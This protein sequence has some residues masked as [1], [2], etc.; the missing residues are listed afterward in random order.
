MLFK[1]ERLGP[2]KKN[3][4]ELGDITLLLGPPNT[5]KSYTLKALYAKLFPLD[6][7]TFNLLRRMLS[8]LLRRHLD[9]VFPED[10]LKIL[11][12]L[13]KTWIETSVIVMV[14]PIHSDVPDRMNETL[15]AL[16]GLVKERN[17]K[18]SIRGRGDTLFVSVKTPPIKLKLDPSI[19]DQTLND[20][21]Y[22]FMSN[23]IPI[24]DIDSAVLDPLDVSRVN[25]NYIMRLF[26]YGT[27]TGVIVIDSRRLLAILDEVL[28]IYN[29]VFERLRH[30]YREL[31]RVFFSYRMLR[32]SLARFP[33]V[34]LETRISPNQGDLE[35]DSVINLTFDFNVSVLE[36]YREEIINIETIRKI[37]NEVF[38]E[39]N[40]SRRLQIIVNRIVDFMKTRVLKAYADT[41]SDNAYRFLRE[42]IV[43]KLGYDSLY[44]IPFGRSTVLLELES[45]SR[46]PYIRA[47]YLHN[48]IDELYPNILASYAY[49]ASRGRGLLL[50]G[51]LTEE[52]RKIL[53]AAKPLLEGDLSTDGSGRLIYRDWRDSKVEMHMASALVGE[54]SG[55][56]LP[57]L[58][59]KRKPLIL[60]EE[61]EAQLHPG[62]Q[63]IMALFIASLPKLC[64]CRIV[65]STHSDLLAITLSQLAVQKPNREWIEE[66]VKSLI[67]HMEKN[68]ETLTNAVAESIKDLEVRIYEYTRQGTVEPVKPEDI[69]SKEVPG[70]SRVIDI[71]TDWAFHLA[72]HRSVER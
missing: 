39:M 2:L 7:Y 48:V 46:E 28:D 29:F 37:I 66:L 31:E 4:I 27:E 25:A 52:Q 35:L 23:L 62:A 11:I 57:L 41:I 42:A 17:F 43:D 51:R 47:R 13:L 70:I 58:T 9:T 32:R 19:L 60:I 12:E 61:P 50:D 15:S 24:E 10:S 49:W 59:V 72:A 8:D 38:K 40:E 33:N 55:L 6:E 63:I 14:S 16:R 71:L 69:L 1:I 56:L 18:L 44:F 45:A 22:R 68:V 65:A 20:A 21:T 26:R 30:K 5:G 36:K 64:S 34:E 3:I 67:P 53:E 54:V